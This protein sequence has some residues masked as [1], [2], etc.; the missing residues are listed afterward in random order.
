MDTDDEKD[1]FHTLDTLLEEERRVLLAGDLTAIRALL[2][3]KETL[4]KQLGTLE[5]VALQLPFIEKRCHGTLTLK[6]S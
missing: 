3:R 4:I 6:H 5:H 2:E 1:L